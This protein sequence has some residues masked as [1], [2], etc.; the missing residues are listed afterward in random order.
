MRVGR[1][2][3]HR[4]L[5]AER[6]APAHRHALD[7]ERH[8]HAD[9]AETRRLR[10]VDVGGDDALPDAQPSRAAQRHVLADGRDQLS[11][12]PRR[13]CGRCRDRP[14]PSSAST[15][16]SRRAPDPPRVRT[17]A[18]NSSLRATKSVSAI[19][20]DEGAAR[21]PP[22]RPRSA[23][24]R[25]RGPAFLAAAGEALLAQPVDRRLEIAGGLAQRLLAVHHAGAGLVAQLLDQRRASSRPSAV[26]PRSQPIVCIGRSGR[27]NGS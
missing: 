10:V 25:R 1:R 4:Q 9:L 16:P 3:M 13:R 21:A 18:W 26:L 12:S 8:Q 24:R 27:S 20:L 19:D 5:S 7:F 2:D 6:R 17:K 23:P 15:S 11:R 14:S 22:P